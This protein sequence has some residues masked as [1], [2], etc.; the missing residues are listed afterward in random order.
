MSGA[1]IVANV[2]VAL[3]AVATPLMAIAD[4]VDARNVGQT[5][6]SATCVTSRAGYNIGVYT[7][8]HYKYRCAAVV[9]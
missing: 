8:S 4:K 1:M 9:R 7:C 6:R 3:A 2:A 5:H